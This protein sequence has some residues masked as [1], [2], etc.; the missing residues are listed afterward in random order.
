MMRYLFC[1]ALSAW[2]V[3]ALAQLRWIAPDTVALGR[4]FT[5]QL[6]GVQ[7]L[8]VKPQVPDTLTDFRPFE[9]VSTEYEADKWTFVLRSFSIDSVQRLSLRL[10]YPR[11]AE[12]TQP[13]VIRFTFQSAL[14]E[15]LKTAQYTWD[16]SLYPIRLPVRWV[17][18]LGIV[19]I[20]LVAIGFSLWFLRMPLKRSIAR[21]HTQRRW[22]LFLRAWAEIER[23]NLAEPERLRALNTL[24]MHHLRPNG[25]PLEAL[26]L[27]ELQTELNQAQFQPEAQ[28][29]LA[30]IQTEYEAFY[31]GRTHSSDRLQA[32]FA[33]LRTAIEQ[34][35]LK[36][37]QTA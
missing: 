34:I 27:H 37:S 15:P 6:V 22:A 1:L 11:G 20:L 19:L 4:P 30:S 31:A 29:L 10:K 12:A 5:V 2:S 24:W 9:V 13:E 14:H 7:G 36:R 21:W 35:E 23:R 33:E 32:L 25:P 16:N 18:V 17:L 3:T 8:A 26:T 28:T